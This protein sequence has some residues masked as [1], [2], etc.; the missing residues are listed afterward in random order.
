MSCNTCNP[1]NNNGI[2]GDWIW[3]IIAIVVVIVLFNDNNNCGGIL[4]NCDCNDRC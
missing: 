4:G 2:F 1:C 3:I